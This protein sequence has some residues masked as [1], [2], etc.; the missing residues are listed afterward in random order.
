MA[1]QGLDRAHIG[2]RLQEV[3]RKGMAKR[4]YGDV[5]QAADASTAC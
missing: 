4:V 5:R 2:A 1:E 3:G